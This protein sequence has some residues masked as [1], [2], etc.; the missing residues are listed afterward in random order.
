MID[1]VILRWFSRVGKAVALDAENDVGFKYQR[2]TKNVHNHF[3]YFSVTLSQMCVQ[4][5]E[6]GVISSRFNR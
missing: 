1:V 4:H 6:L 2:S 3:E 5:D